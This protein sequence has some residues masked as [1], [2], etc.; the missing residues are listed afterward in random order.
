[1][2][3]VATGLWALGAGAKRLALPALLALGLTS[4]AIAGLLLPYNRS[5]T[6]QATYDPIT[7]YFD[8]RY[9]PGSNR[10]GFGREVGNVGWTGLDPLLG[11]GPVDVLVNANANFYMLNFDL[12]GWS[13]G[14][15]WFAVVLVLWGRW[16][17]TDWLFLTTVLLI[18]GGMSLYWFSGGP[19][20][21][22]RYWY[23]TQ[24]P[25]VILTVR[26]MQVVRDR[27]ATLAPLAGIGERLWVFIAVASLVA[28]I[29][30]LPWRSL[31]KYHNYRG[32]RPDIRTLSRDYTF[33]NSLVLIQSRDNKA[34]PEYSSAAIFNPP[35][36][37][38]P[39]TI[40]ARD[41]NPS[42]T[43][44][45]RKHFADRPLWI[46]AA[47]SVTGK[48]M[49]VVGGPTVTAQRVSTPPPAPGR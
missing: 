28:F 7:K 2:I 6:G 29:N 9:Y 4:I 44:L 22:A 10:L 39:G 18:I 3:G 14:S 12:F 19:D 17:R 36:L 21:G 30:V 15:L 11:H 49:Q 20:F 31:D 32:M 48:G 45:L 40:Y 16:T 5:L 23:Q 13:F 34:F 33:G 35:S 46:V 41:L 27:L 26:G 38:Q 37:E 8:E 43:D 47:P 1:L 24:V 25:M 42:K